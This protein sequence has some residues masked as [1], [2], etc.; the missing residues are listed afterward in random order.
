MASLDRLNEDVVLIVDDVP[1]NLSLLHDA[2]D[3]AGYAVLVATNG[4]SALQ[5]ARQT[6]PDVILLDAVMP[7]MDGFEVARQLKADPATEPIPII[8]MTGLTDT[9]HVVAAFS[10]GS[11]D[12]VTKPIRPSEVLARI[13]RHVQSARQMHQARSVLDAYGQACMAIRPTDGALLWQT[14]LSRTLMHKYGSA[15]EARLAARLHAWLQAA[16]AKP[17]PAAPLE[18]MGEEGRMVCA[19]HGRTDEGECLVVLH[20]ESNSA[21]TR[22]LVDAFRVTEREAEV[23]YW[24]IHGK[25]NRDIGDILGISHRT[26]NKHLENLFEKLGV[27]TRTAAA[28]VAMRRLQQPG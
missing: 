23:L 13:A 20:E 1:E 28:A 3:E 27:E 12:Y 9:E 2:L 21:M 19:L 14:P 5:R 17:Q 16:L 6:M 26:I 8:F 18:I 7:G 22:V 11:A 25:T 15:D 10:V 24:V 4:E